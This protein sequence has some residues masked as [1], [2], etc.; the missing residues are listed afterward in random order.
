MTTEENEVGGQRRKEPEE[1]MAV[2][3]RDLP[4]TMKELDLAIANGYGDTPQ[5]SLPRDWRTRRKGSSHE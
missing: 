3:R 5:R 1:E 2:V 4:L